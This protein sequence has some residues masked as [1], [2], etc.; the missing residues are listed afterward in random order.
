M[1][2]PGAG[3]GSGLTKNGRGEDAQRMEGGV[4]AANT[5]DGVYT[6]IWRH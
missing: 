1:L 2:G 6:L 3:T 4:T 5:G